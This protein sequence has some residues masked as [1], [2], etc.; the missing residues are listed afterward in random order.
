MAGQT[1]PN[2]G[3]DDCGAYLVASVE[4]RIMDMTRLSAFRITLFGMVELITR[5]MF[6]SLN[7]SILQPFGWIQYGLSYSNSVYHRRWGKKV[8]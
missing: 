5:Q 7:R 4:T 2:G 3:L 8:T 1:V 6:L